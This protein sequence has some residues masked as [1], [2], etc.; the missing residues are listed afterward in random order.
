MHA[1]DCEATPNP[2]GRNC[3]LLVKGFVITAK[4]VLAGRYT[5]VIDG[6]PLQ[7]NSAV[8]FISRLL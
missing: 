1:R 7:I 4:N 6:S 2:N 8:E 5:T 3:L